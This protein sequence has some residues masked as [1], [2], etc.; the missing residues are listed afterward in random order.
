MPLG[1]IEFKC[2]DLEVWVERF[3]LV[4]LSLERSLRRVNIGNV[5]IEPL[6]AR[7]DVT[8]LEYIIHLMIF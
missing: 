2:K 4:E 1:G 8:Y 3:S 5:R 6:K 7:Q